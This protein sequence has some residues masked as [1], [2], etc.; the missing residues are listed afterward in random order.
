MNND[1]WSPIVELRQY[2]L[3]PGRRDALIGLFDSEFVESQEDTGIKVIGQFR[4]L[5]DPNTFVWLRGFPSMAQRARSLASFYDGPIWQQNR[6]A[7][8]AT[9]ID[10]DNVL[11]LRPARP[12]STFQ[13]DRG[14]PVGNELHPGIVEAT[15]LYFK[16]LADSAI[17]ATFEQ[18]IAPA[19]QSLGGT[20][21]GS[22]V[23]EPSA[24]TFPRLPV[25]EGE[26]VFVW[27]AGFAENTKR[28]S[29]LTAI[30]PIAGLQDQPQVLRLDPTSRSLLTARCKPCL[31]A[32]PNTRL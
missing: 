21:L 18:E 11:L 22:F 2:T 9:M 29:V 6:G 4:D 28:D 7:A 13:L 15:I 10:S 26:C 3:H 12:N 32:A 27:F 31:L 8:N 14:R 20:I 24:N 1:T 17:S 23:T 5:D 25:R 16:T 19:V 30:E